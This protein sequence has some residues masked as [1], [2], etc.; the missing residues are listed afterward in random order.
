MEL[1]E[2][3]SVPSLLRINDACRV[4]G[5]GRS[6]LYQLIATGEIEAVKIG[7]RTLVP[8]ASLERF[9]RS[10]PSMRTTGGLNRGRLVVK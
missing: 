2:P 6:K 9:I 7:T 4:I 3:A 8:M 5:L 10:L 1:L